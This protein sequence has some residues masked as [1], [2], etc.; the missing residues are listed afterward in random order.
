MGIVCIISHHKRL[1]NLDSQGDLV[2]MQKN[3]INNYIQI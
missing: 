2:T 3:I 1:S